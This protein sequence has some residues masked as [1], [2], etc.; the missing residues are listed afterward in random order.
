MTKR[1]LLPLRCLLRPVFRYGW[2]AF[3]I[4]V[5]ALCFWV[6]TLAATGNL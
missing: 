1:F 2:I 6:V 4:A 5:W 3:V